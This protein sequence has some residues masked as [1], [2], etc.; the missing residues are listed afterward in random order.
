VLPEYSKQSRIPLETA[1]FIATEKIVMID[2]VINE[3]ISA[4][5]RI[6]SLRTWQFINH[7]SLGRK[8]L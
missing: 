1:H 7:V 6:L 4:M 8:F 3:I 2:S 5:L